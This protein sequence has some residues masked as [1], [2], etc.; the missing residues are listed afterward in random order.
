M[1]IRYIEMLPPNQR[2]W[3]IIEHLYYI[4]TEWM[5]ISRFRTCSHTKSGVLYT[6]YTV[7]RVSSSSSAIANLKPD[8]QGNSGPLQTLRQG[9]LGFSRIKQEANFLVL[10]ERQCEEA[11]TSETGE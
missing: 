3:K 10:E 4:A 9:L 1:G 6:L 5:R 7:G 2:P 11:R 8:C